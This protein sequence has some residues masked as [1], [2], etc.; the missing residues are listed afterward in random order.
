[1]QSMTDKAS[2]KA[3]GTARRRARRGVSLIEILI[4]LVILVVGILTIIRL[5]PSGFFS[6]ESVGNAALADSLGIAAVQAQTQ[7]A[8]GLPDAILPG[9][10]DANG[11]PTATVSDGSY[12]P[13]KAQN[14]DNAHV[15]YNETLTVPSA[16]TI[17]GVSQSVYVV[18]YGPIQMGT[19]S[20]GGSLTQLPQYVSINSLPWAQSSG[21]ANGPKNSTPVYPQDSLTVGQPNFLV[22]LASK[23]IAVPYAAYTPTSATTATSYA[24]KM[25]L[26]IFA[27]DGKAYHEYLNVPA[28]TPRD[29][30]TGSTTA[31]APKDAG[32]INY[33]PDT[34]TN[35]QGGWFDPTS[36]TLYADP[37]TSTAPPSTVTWTKVVL[38][39]PFA[40]VVNTGTFTSDPYEFMLPNAN[41][42][43]MASSPQ[44]NIGA[45]AFNPLGA[46]RVGVKPLQAQITYQN[47]GWRILHE[48]R[49]IAALTPG[50]TTVSRLTLKN[51][52]RVGDADPDNNIDTGLIPGSSD[53]FII[54][55]LDTGKVLA[56][57]TA[58]S[59]NTLNDEDTNGT[60]S[61]AINVSYAIGRVTFPQ[62]VFP[63]GLSHHVRIYYAGDADWTVAVQKAPR[64]YTR[65]AD[66][67]GA[68]D[69]MIGP[70]QCAYNSGDNSLYFPRCD[71][72]K[73]VT[74]EG[75]TS[76]AS[77]VPSPDVTVAIGNVVYPFG[78]TNY[79]RVDNLA[80]GSPAAFSAVR[81][82]SARAVVAWKERDLW[83]VHSVD[84]VLSQT[85]P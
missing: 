16:R 68:A 10:M 60:I 35:Y 23:Q 57:T 84:T 43:G 73:T 2:G 32:N 9:S 58:A 70:G 27:S 26:W 78:G 83:K 80:A 66:F 21:D 30:S 72:G 50:N 6:V 61:T 42:V 4:V 62:S 46:G 82:L 48:D 38:Y 13:D 5:F 64:L 20:P 11:Q 8:V 85:Q 79:V 1:M 55:D 36:T 40:G 15:I 81:G 47:Y 54:Q 31:N 65:I 41:I 59:P 34:V 28:A 37:V 53:G 44:G 63:D 14:L 33:L 75:I 12:D 51:L 25:V 24:Q 3:I 56:D 76:G 45:I 7:N 74:I 29:T 52:R 77:A 71:A 17:N 67:S 18:N 19:V 39:R 49:D 69:P 22:D